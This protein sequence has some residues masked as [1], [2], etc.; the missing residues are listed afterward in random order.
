M[1]RKAFTLIELLV[2]IAIIAIL[3]A[4]LFPVFA[5]AKAAAKKTTSLSN[6]KQIGLGALIYSGDADDQIPIAFGGEYANRNAIDG[7]RTQFWPELIFPYVKSWGIYAD[8]IRGDSRGYFNTGSS[9]GTPAQVGDIRNKGRFPMYGVNYLF[10]SPFPDCVKSESKSYTQA[11]DSAG[12]VYLT[13]SQ[14]FTVD[15]TRGFYNVN[16]PGMWPIVSPHPV[17]CIFF[18]GTVGS[19]NWSGNNPTS[20]KKISASTY[21]DGGAGS[22]VTFLDGHSKYLNDGALTAGTDYGSATSANSAEGATIT[23]RSKYLWNLDSEYYDG[24]LGGA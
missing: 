22:N 20:P 14:Q 24:Y 15:K 9:L 6:A 21:L 4:I 3:A 23:D 7:T 12:T 5:Q 2:V 11:E 19:G 1:Q 17:Y 18:D 8:P 10:L 16:A 13:V